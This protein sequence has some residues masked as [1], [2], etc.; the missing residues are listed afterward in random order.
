MRRRHSKE[1]DEMWAQPMAPTRRRTPVT[2]LTGFLGSGKT[3]LLNRLLRDA[4]AGRVAVIVN[5]FGEVGLDHDLIESTAEALTLMRSGCLCCTVRGDLAGTLLDL[6]RRRAAGD[7]AFDR[8]VIET[9][10]LADP[11]PILHTL[12]VDPMIADGYALDGVVTTADAVTGDATLDTQFEAVNQIAMADRIVVTKTDVAPHDRT[13]AFEA[14]LRAIN[15]AAPLLRP[16]SARFEPG[17][18][19]D[20]GGLAAEGAPL[21]ALSWLGGPGAS[22]PALDR[23][24]SG[25]KPADRRPAPVGFAH[26][27]R[28]ASLSC[29]IDRPIAPRMFDLW[30][31][32]LMAMMGQDILRLKAI[33]HIEGIETPFA[34]HGVRHVLEPPAPL[35]R[36]PSDDRATR[37]VI[38]GRDLPKA[39]IED[40]FAFLRM[41]EGEARDLLGLLDAAP[42]NPA[43]RR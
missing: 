18:L 3:T 26:D 9:T 36:W 41:A 11:T 20:I 42:R 8:V 27:A 31:E 29:V 2:L 35:P 21:R 1:R 5:E 43:A 24:L 13:A 32:T 38:I 4:S 28:I 34:L 37:I 17:A 16:L 40:G 30:L 14:R 25:L 12:T 39:L 33:V 23:P 22:H 6:G 7:I 10:G 19:F 15:P